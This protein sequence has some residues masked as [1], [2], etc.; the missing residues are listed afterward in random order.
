MDKSFVLYYVAITIFSILSM[1]GKFSGQPIFYIALISFG[2]IHLFYFRIYSHI[3]GLNLSKGL[4][5]SII[6]GLIL[7]TI[8]GNFNFVVETQ[9][10]AKDYFLIFSLFVSFFCGLICFFVDISFN[11]SFRK[12]SKL[13]ILFVS[14]GFYIINYIISFIIAFVLTGVR[15]LS[16]T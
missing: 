11:K 5:Y 2:I 13:K 16:F 12:S 7:L 3:T 14:I 6:I 9:N 10:N 8:S 4:L 1:F 15:A